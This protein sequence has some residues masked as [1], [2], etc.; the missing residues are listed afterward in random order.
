MKVVSTLFPGLQGFIERAQALDAAD[1]LAGFRDRFVIADPDLIYLLANSLGRLP[2]ATAKQMAAVVQ[3]EWGERLIRGWNEGWIDL[4]QRIGDKLGR[5]L[6]ARPGEIIVADSTSVN[7]FK[8]VVAALRMR[9]GRTKILTDDLNFPSDL[10]ILQG[11][12]QAAGGRHQLE[13][14]PSPDG[15]QGPVEALAAAMDENTALVA[16]SHTLFKSSYTYDMAAM[17]G[18]AH[19]AGALM[20]WDVS[21]AAG[22]VPI[23]FQAAQADFAVGCTYKY[24][25]GGP[26]APAFLYVQE[27]LQESVHNPISGWM[28]QDNPF[29]LELQYRSAPGI[30]RFLT[31]TPS[32]LSLAAIEPGLNLILEAGSNRLRWKAEKQTDFLIEL[33]AEQLQPVGFTLKSPRPAG[34][35]GA[36]V[37]FGHPEA[38]RISEALKKE[39]NVIPDFRR[40]DNL[41]FAV[42]PLYTRYVELVEA[43]GRLRR[44]VENRLYAKYPQASPVVT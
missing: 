10:Y 2:K 3:Q 6:G 44:V 11:A 26:G 22:V 12:I 27:E 13:I 15:I 29:A 34:M 7:L 37:T 40:P 25:C 42:A 1:D 24:L 20:L 39:M 41:R 36:H 28:G 9:P 5:L 8:L 33:W 38:L 17:T 18:K 32:I 19:A 16:L 14:I 30:R 31:G 35:R 4:P 43:A 23:D 21:H